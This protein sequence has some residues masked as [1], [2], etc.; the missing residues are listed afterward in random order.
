M[1]LLLVS[2]GVNHAAHSLGRWTVA[3][4]VRWPHSHVCCSGCL[5]AGPLFVGSRSPGGSFTWW[6]QGKKKERKEFIRILKTSA[7]SS[8]ITSVAFY[9][10]KQVTRPDS[11]E[12]GET[13]S[14]S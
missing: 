2:P 5:P 10:S 14:I 7:Q 6:F 12:R 11:C 8:D 3:G 1:V 9:W 4:A 13:D